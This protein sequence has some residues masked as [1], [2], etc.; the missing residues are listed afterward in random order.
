[1]NLCTLYI[2]RH[3]ET[4]WN[5]KGKVQGHT[6]IALSLSG[7]R[8]A[9][10]KAAFFKDIPLA[11]VISS[12]LI[13]A[14]ETAEI[15]MQGREIPFQ[16]SALLREQSWGSWEGRLFDDIRA[17]FGNEFNEY[18]GTETHNVPGVESHLQVAKRVEPFLQ[19]IGSGFLGKSLLIV[20]HGGVLKSLVFYLNLSHLFHAR[21]DNL[22]FVQLTSDGVSFGFVDAQGLIV[23]E[24]GEV[25]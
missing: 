23:R 22:G 14:K 13:R 25:K 18:T 9:E 16:M 12:D 19:S 10:E 5:R 15:L 2:V 11:G 3:G 4:E 1:M 21:F 17:E 20:T 24:L 7:R 6:D 8:Q